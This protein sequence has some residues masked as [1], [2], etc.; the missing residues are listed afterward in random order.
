MEKKHAAEV[1]SLTDK[2]QEMETIHRK[3]M[4]AMEEKLQVL[5]RVMLNQSNTGIDMGD[6]GAFLSTRNDDNNVRHSSTSNH[7]IMDVKTN[8]EDIQ[9]KDNYPCR[10]QLLIHNGK[11]LKDETTLADNEVS[12]DGF[13]VVMLSKVNNRSMGGECFVDNYEE[14]DEEHFFDESDEEDEEKFFDDLDEDEDEE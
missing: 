9:E 14:E 1:K 13:L 7:E 6:L 10:Q 11:V 3:D 12:E 4:A 2:V 8:I 5:L